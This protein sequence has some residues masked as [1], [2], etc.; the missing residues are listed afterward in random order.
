MNEANLAASI[1][2]VKEA[3]VKAAAE[4]E[5][6]E[7]QR[8]VAKAQQAALEQDLRRTENL[9]LERL[10]ELNQRRS[11]QLKARV[12]AEE[13]AASEIAR[14]TNAAG[15]LLGPIGT[16]AAG[17]TSSMVVRPAETLQE[18]S[19][20]AEAKANLEALESRMLKLNQKVDAMDGTIQSAD[21]AVSAA[22]EQLSRT[23]AIVAAKVDS[24]QS[25][26][27]NNEVVEKAEGLQEKLEKN[28]QESAKAIEKAIEGV[29]PQNAKEKAALEELKTVLEDGKVLPEETQKVTRALND[30][31]ALLNGNF[32]Q[33][34]QQLQVNAQT[35]SGILRSLQTLQSQALSDRE[36][37]NGL[38]RSQSR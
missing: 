7:Y 23:Q 19:A 14:R 9:Y 10:D 2:A 22:D 13:E 28:A 31:Y 38:L 18:D 12:R 24:L 35:Q 16:I 17:A 37:V 32:Q 1:A 36:K 3:E 34:V 27:T 15:G 30:L 11:D 6:A 5:A 21:R 4:R 8:W 25:I 20:V 26:A 29:E 33:I